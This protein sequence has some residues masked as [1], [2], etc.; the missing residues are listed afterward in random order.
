MVE[1]Q[2]AGAI[3]QS[4]LL[5]KSSYA[6]RKAC[7]GG[8][9]KVIKFVVNF[10]KD[11]LFLILN[12]I[13]IRFLNVFRSF[14]YSYLTLI[15]IL[16]LSYLELLSCVNYQLPLRGLLITSNIVLPL[17]RCQQQSYAVGGNFV[18]LKVVFIKGVPTSTYIVAELQIRGVL[19]KRY[20]KIFYYKVYYIQDLIKRYII[21]FRLLYNALKG[22]QE[23]SN[24]F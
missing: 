17:V 7:R 12:I 6:W 11:R 13:C 23:V 22:L 16:V 1:A 15:Y 20:L 5:I 18:R 24:T 3:T 14:L 2:V 10:V 9:N 19:F 4:K 8:I 21:T